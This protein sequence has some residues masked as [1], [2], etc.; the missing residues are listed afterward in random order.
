LDDKSDVSTIYIDSS[1]DGE[2]NDKVETV[3]ASVE[4]LQHLYSVFLPPHLCLEA[5]MRDKHHKITN[6]LPIYTRE[7]W[8]TAWRRNIAQM[9]VAKGCASLDG[10]VMCKVST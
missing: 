3:E 4:A 1:D 2:C 9:N 10:F 5:K 8:T 6:R 7:L